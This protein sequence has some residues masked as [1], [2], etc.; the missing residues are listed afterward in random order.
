MGVKKGFDKVHFVAPVT[1]GSKI[2]GHTKVAEIDAKKPPAW[3]L[4]G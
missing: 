3:L 1:V 2:R 4:N